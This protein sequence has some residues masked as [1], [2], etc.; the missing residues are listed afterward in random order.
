MK[1]TNESQGDV[2]DLSGL[3]EGVDCVKLSGI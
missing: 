2:H 1:D 3:Q